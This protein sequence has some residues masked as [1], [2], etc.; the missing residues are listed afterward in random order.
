MEVPSDGQTCCLGM[1]AL[2]LRVQVWDIVE[3]LPRLEW[4]LDYYYFLL[5]LKGAP[6]ILAGEI[7][8]ASSTAD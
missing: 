3:R 7:L 8:T 2:L 5:V 4:P 1:F 6:M